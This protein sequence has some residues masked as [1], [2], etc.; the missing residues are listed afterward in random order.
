MSVLFGGRGGGVVVTWRTGCMTEWV[1][2]F[3]GRH[4]GQENYIMLAS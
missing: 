1:I 4:K 3:G 2:D